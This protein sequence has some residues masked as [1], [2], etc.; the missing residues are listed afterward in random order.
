MF[1]REKF[2]FRSRTKNVYETDLYRTILQ[3]TR[4]YVSIYVF[5][6]RV[7][8]FDSFS[9]PLLALFLRRRVEFVCTFL[10]DECV[11][12]LPYAAMSSDCI[13]SLVQQ[14]QQATAERRYFPSLLMLMLMKRSKNT[15]YSL[16]TTHKTHTDTQ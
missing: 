8:Y 14:E 12:F 7:C 10:D 5:R 1:K 2:E 13:F 6:A 16:L 3:G 11:L 9:R 4:V 15:L